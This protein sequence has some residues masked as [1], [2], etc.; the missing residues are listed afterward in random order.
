MKDHRAARRYSRALFELAQERGELD[1]LERDLAEI[2][3]LLERHDA[4][5]R[6]VLNSTISPSDKEASLERML[7]GRVSPLALTFLKVLVKKSRFLEFTTVQEDF[8]KRYEAKK[9]LR[10]VTALTAQPLTADA[11]TKLLGMLR[12]KLSSEIRLLAKT[13]PD[14]IGGLVLR[15]DGQEIDASY[16]NRLR[17]LRQILLAS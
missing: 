10:E 16:K 7:S 15:F 11:E 4:I 3:G 2:G 12:K 9:G 6:I 13:D 1:A 8:H 17:E 5:K 14:L